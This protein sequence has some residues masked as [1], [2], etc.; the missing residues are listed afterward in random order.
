MKSQQINLREV[1]AIAN[2]LG[3]APTPVAGDDDSRCQLGQIYGLANDSRFIETNFSEPLTTFAVGYQDPNNI[4]DALEFFAPKVI[5]PGRLFEWKKWSNAEEFYQEVDDQRAIGADF[6]RVEYT[7]IDQ[8]AKTIN[9]GLMML[10]DLD[11]VPLQMPG[12]ENRFVAKLVRRLLR[13]ELYRAIAILVG[14]TTPTTKKWDVNT[15]PDSDIVQAGVTSADSQGF[16]FNRVG[17]GH[18]AWAQR[19]LSL[20]GNANAAKFATAGMT[21][22]QLAPVLGVDECYVVK[23][24]YQSTKSTK[25]QVVGAQV[26]MFTARPG[27]DVE[28]PSNIKR[29]VS[30][31]PN[32][33]TDAGGAEITRPQGALDLNVYMRQV[34]AKIVQ[35]SVEHYSNIILTS[36]LGIVVYNISSS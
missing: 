22:E 6:K 18:S 8:T 20:R 21:P 24:R 1:V 17:Y 25:S 11:Q 29:F 14:A 19:F 30:P 28:D 27:Q 2:R 31:P 3:F 36:N 23:E 13:N 5:V 34:S 26:A 4:E 7:G 33:F 35:I 12:W 10:I 32:V 9:K 16:Q 15:D